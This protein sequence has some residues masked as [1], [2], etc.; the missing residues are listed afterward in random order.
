[1]N[2]VNLVAALGSLSSEHLMHEAKR[3]L[4]SSA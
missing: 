2:L 1:M 3:R 4:P